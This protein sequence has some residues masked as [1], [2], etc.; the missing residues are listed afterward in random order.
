MSTKVG[1]AIIIAIAI[2][3]ILLNQTE[4]KEWLESRVEIV[5]PLTSWSRVLEGIYLKETLK[6]SPYESD[7]IHELPIMLKFYTFIKTKLLFNRATLINY[8]FITIDVI[9][10]LLLYKISDKI[11]SYLEQCELS[12]FKMGKY[13]KLFKIQQLLANIDEIS[14]NNGEKKLK[15]E[16]EKEESFKKS[17][18]FLLSSFNNTYLSFI[19]LI[20]Y[21]LN[22]LVISNCIVNSTSVINNLILCLWLFVL[23]TD[24][25]RLSLIFLA[26]SSHISV[27][28]IMLIVPTLLYVYINP[29][30]LPES[31][32]KSKKSIILVI[33]KYLTFFII[34]LIGIFYI[35]LY[36][37]GNN[38]KFIKSTYLF[39][40]QVPDL[41][42][43][44]GLFWYFFTEIFDHFRLFFTW[45]FQ[46]NA[47]IFIIPLA[48]RLKHNPIMLIYIQIGLIAVLKSYPC[49]GD[50]G[51]YLSLL[52][53]FKYLF[54]Y[55]RNLLIYTCMLIVSVILAP[56]MW[57]LWIYSGSGN[58]NFYFAITLVYSLSQ[59]FMLV[60]LLY[61]HLKREYIKLNGDTIP[62]LDNGTLATF[63]IE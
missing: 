17:A 27:Y 38:T 7:L 30:Q 52:P 22:P 36:L 24:R 18:R 59:I 54:K 20:L 45:V 6:V 35:N 10:G 43:N 42:P 9:I 31:T 4:L 63:S 34:Y 1:I 33:L 13:E 53:T 3:V 11:L 25:I 41:Q 12:E 19:T 61:A 26:L 28:P 39:I 56:I 60:D 51:L 14:D 55:M 50:A 8:F 23:L 48:I 44:L 29:T 49:I 57:H 58:A 21:Y 15:L 37:E 62:I 46:L 47:F 40:L 16:R 5:T 32:S 2:R